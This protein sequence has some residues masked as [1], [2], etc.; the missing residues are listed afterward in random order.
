MEVTQSEIIKWKE[1][2]CKQRSGRERRRCN[3]MD[4]AVTKQQSKHECAGEEPS[5]DR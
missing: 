4:H 2:K 1:Q 3:P 5:Q